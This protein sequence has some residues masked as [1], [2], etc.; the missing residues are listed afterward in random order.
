MS[1][2][3]P[4]MFKCSQMLAF[5]AAFVDMLPRTLLQNAQVNKASSVNKK[6]VKTCLIVD[7]VRKNWS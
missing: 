2:D 4:G 6:I 3:C 5:L 7:M 1:W